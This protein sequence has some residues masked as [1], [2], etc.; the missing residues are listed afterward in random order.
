MKLTFS[1]PIEAADTERRIISGK[2]MEYGAIGQTSA[3]PVMFEHGSIQVPNTGK[4]KLLAQHEPNNPIGRAQSFSTEG[5]FIYGSFKISNSS[6]GT[7]YLTLAAEDLVSGLSVGVE[8]ISSLPKDNY[9]LVTAA[10]LKE[11]SLVESPAFEN[12]VVTKVA[13][14][15]SEAEQDNT[16]P[17]TES[18][19]VMTTAPETK[20]PETEAEAPVV[21]A[22]RPVVSASYLVGEVRSPIKTNAQYLEHTIKAQMGNDVSR[23][24]IRAADAQAKKIEA[25]NDSFTTN[26]AFSPVQY[27]SNVIDTSVMSRPTIDALGGARALAASGMTVSHPKITTSATIST[28]AEGGS[29][30]ATQIVSAY[31]NAT[32]V[33]LAGT[34]I[35]STEL[36]DRSDPSFYAAMYENCLRAYAKASD[37]AVIAEIVSGGTQSSTQAATIAGLQAYVAQAAPAVYAAAGETATAFIAGTSVWSLLI[38]SLDTTGRSIFNAASPMNANGQSTPRGL[39]GD[40]MGLDLWVDANMVSTTIDDCAFIVNP[41]SIA[42]Y[43]SPK[44][45]LSVNVVATGE[46]S[47][48]LYGYF[49]TKTL[50]SGGLQR[51]NLT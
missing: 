33:K 17:Q 24:Y 10:S 16:N 34:Q 19:A 37:A 38:G 18:E 31:V 41:M 15:E 8:V 1:T 28:V 11:V 47:T 3:G 23:D 2:V 44:L 20:A 22:S 13:A 40:M 35:M 21:E 50:V 46:I 6:K 32:V 30:A 43:E 12:A 27:V 25:A 29:T 14:S 48:M 7:D 5:D 9:L 39:R 49:A 51:Y 4:I 42:I 45:T 26:P 36:L